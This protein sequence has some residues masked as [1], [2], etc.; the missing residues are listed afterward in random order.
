MQKVQESY[1]NEIKT[2]VNSGITIVSSTWWR[3]FYLR[4][5]I[6]YT[7]SMEDAMKLS[8]K[9]NDALAAHDKKVRPNAGGKKYRH[10][11]CVYH[12]AQS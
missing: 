7:K 1:T 11:Q 2:Y 8:Q 9:I 3:L 12:E 10:A 4:T 6:D 5:K